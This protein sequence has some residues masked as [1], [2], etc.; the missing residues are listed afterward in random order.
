MY[1]HT[2]ERER[3]VGCRKNLEEYGTIKFVERV[4]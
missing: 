3:K 1:I 2:L 4:P